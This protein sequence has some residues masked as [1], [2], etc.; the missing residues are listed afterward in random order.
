MPN[1]IAR[2]SQYKDDQPLRVKMFGL[3]SAGCNMIEGAQYST[4]AFSTSSA[5]LARSHAERK[6][7]IGPERLVG[8]S[9]TKHSIL[10]H[11]PSIAGHEIVD[12]FNNT[13][14]AFMFC[15]LGGL[16]GSMGVKLFSS[17]AQAK[18]T[19]SIVLAATPFSA[20]SIRRRELASR[21]L[22][23]ILSA[24]TLCIEFDNDMLSSLAPNLPISRAF[25][26]MN[27]IMQRPVIDACSTMT[28]TDSGIL[29]QVLG[30][31]TYGRFG[32]GLARGDERVKNV[33]E[34][35]FSS[36]WFNYP[37][38]E[39]S[40]AVAVYS[41]SD[42]WDKEAERIQGQ[43]SAKLPSARIAWGS[44]KDQGLNDRIRLSLIICRKK[45]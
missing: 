25:S 28:R 38:S 6:M 1:S 13:D 42:P 17:I 27:G 23:E 45:A 29:K 37:L 16:T 40:A 41:S 18:G 36:P 3:G 12:V 39:A 32:L 7:L 43:I 35:A 20:E 5:D 15:G 14:I 22:D 33:V 4:F 10:K 31:A 30:D 44:Y 19:A 9:E 2:F 24:T 34:E 11:L 8:I 26:L 21:T